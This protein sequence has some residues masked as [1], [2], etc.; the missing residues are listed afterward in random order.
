M[1]MRFAGPVVILVAM[2]AVFFSPALS[3]PQTSR[4][5]SQAAAAASSQARGRDRSP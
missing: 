4:A 3:A 2:A 5:A 1:P